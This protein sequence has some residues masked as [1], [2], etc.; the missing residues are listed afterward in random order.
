MIGP[1]STPTLIRSH[2]DHENRHRLCLLRCTQLPSVSRSAPKS[3]LQSLV[4]SLVLT[5]LGLPAFRCIYR[6]L[7]RL[8]SVMNS[9]AQLQCSHRRGIR[10]PDHF[11]NHSTPPPTALVESRDVDWFQAHCPCQHGA[12]P[13]S[14]RRDELGRVAD[15][16]AR[17][18]LR[19][20]SSPS[21][22]VHRTRGC[23]RRT[24]LS[25]RRN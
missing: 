5:R 2:V 3:V 6:L 13:S 4:T 23:C 10:S 17:R 16:D 1:P 15:F 9:A 14:C 20:A 25:S 7:K 8:Q 18:R 11:T 12:A 19:S 24:I 22:I 21:M